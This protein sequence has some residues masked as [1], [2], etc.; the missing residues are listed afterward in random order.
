[1]T[2]EKLIE[3]ISTIIQEPNIYKNG[4]TLTYTLKKEE[5]ESLNEELFR[6]YNP[7]SVIPFTPNDEFEVQIEGILVT[8]IKLK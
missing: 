6:Q 5:H 2:Y 1:M 8:F 4:L 7:Y 3:T